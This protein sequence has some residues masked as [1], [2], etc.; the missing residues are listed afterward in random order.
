L[1]CPF[2]K[3]CTYI[4]LVTSVQMGILGH[5]DRNKRKQSS[6]PHKCTTCSDVGHGRRNYLKKDAVAP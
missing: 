6:G 4:H 1:V 2:Q 3:M 5:A